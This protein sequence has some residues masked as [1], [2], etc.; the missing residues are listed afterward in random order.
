VPRETLARGALRSAPGVIASVQGSAQAR[1][2]AEHVRGKRRWK[3]QQ[4]RARSKHVL[5][6]GP[7]ELGEV[8]EGRY[9]IGRAAFKT[10]LVEVSRARLEK[11]LYAEY[12]RL[13]DWIARLEGAKA[14]QRPDTLAE[15]WDLPVDGAQS[16]AEELVEVGFFE[17]RGTKQEP[18]YWVPFLYRDAL[19][20][21]R[22]VAAGPDV[23]DE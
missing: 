21:V 3:A 15:I 18:Q 23:E 22:G 6:R 5:P 11:T 14:E 12:P 9:L 20:L 13:R 10:G 17:L 2:L 1:A 4:S 19:N 7:L 8:D 16:I